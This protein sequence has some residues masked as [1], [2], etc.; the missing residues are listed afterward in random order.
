MAFL[1][2]N[3]E[4]IEPQQEF[5]PIPA[6]RYNAIITDSDIKETK[7]GTGQMLH[8]TWKITDG[9]MA[10][11]LVFDRIN[12]VNQN[13]TAEEIGQRQFS[14]LCRAVGVM[15]VSDT[16]Q[17]HGIPCVIRVAIKIDKTGQ[18]PDSNDVKDYRQAGSVAPTA[19]A[20]ASGFA[21]PGAATPTPP[22]AAKAA[23]PAAPWASNRAG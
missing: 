17:L 9:P 14:T 11:R 20:P 2:F 6:G 8:L 12:I 4:A 10:N 15:Q 13:P 16:Q 23:A 22:P 5:T 7:S 21:A 3:A 18:Y 19:H 1:Q